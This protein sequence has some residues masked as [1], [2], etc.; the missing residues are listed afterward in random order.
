MVVTDALGFLKAVTTRLCS[1]GN[2]AVS[3]KR[4]EAYGDDA[5][6]CDAMREGP[7]WIAISCAAARATAFVH[8]EPHSSEN[9]DH[10]D[11][12]LWIQYVPSCVVLRWI[13]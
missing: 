5:K 4:L 9:I 1:R 2:G 7:M 12:C 13:L 10:D 8:A 11:E 3:P 6:A